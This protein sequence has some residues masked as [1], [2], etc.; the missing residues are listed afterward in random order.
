M[1]SRLFDAISLQ[2]GLTSKGW[3]S[4]PFHDSTE[5]SWA[6]A[7]IDGSIETQTS[8]ARDIIQLKKVGNSAQ[9]TWIQN[10]THQWKCMRR[11]TPC[12]MVQPVR[13]SRCVHETSSAAVSQLTTN[14]ITGLTECESVLYTAAEYLRCECESRKDHMLRDPMLE[15]SR[16]RTP[17]AH[18]ARRRGPDATERRQTNRHGAAHATPSARQPPERRAS[19]R[20]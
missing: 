9:T 6:L 10:G 7:S 18:Q 1:R 16:G 12:G 20:N 15:R 2:K 17:T 3:N 19:R 4:Y 5:G 13:A 11:E 14:W 8:I